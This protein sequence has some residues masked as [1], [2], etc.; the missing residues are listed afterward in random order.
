MIAEGGSFY[1]VVTRDGTEHL[2][3]VMPVLAQSNYLGKNC[4]TCHAVAEG[5]PLGAITLEVELARNKAFVAEF[6]NGM[7]AVGM[8][9]F[10]PLAVLSW[11]ALTAMVTMP[12]RRLSANLDYIAR[13][14]AALDLRLPVRGGKELA[15]AA[16][17]FNRVLEKAANMLERERIASDVF[18]HALEGIVVA[19]RDARIV[20]VNPAFTR[21]T[22]YSEEE[23]LGRNPS[24]L[25]SGRHDA[26][27]YRSF[28]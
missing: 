23:A 2:R 8:L 15:L 9:L 21:T 3:A 7:I 17:S 27:F 1:D 5:T 20:K 25:Q 6:Q 14:D 11:L 19:D 26:S 24:M 22:G 10:V 16:E 12:L 18:D 13:G 28:W 4:L